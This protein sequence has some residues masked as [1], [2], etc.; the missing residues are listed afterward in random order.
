M[1]KILISGA[2]VLLL[3]VLFTVNLLK[4]EK[5]KE[6][7]A[8]KV[9]YG[10]VQQTVTGSGQIRPAVEVKVSAQ[11]AG[12][13]VQLNAKEGDRVK[14]G[15]LLAALDPEQYLASVERA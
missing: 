9:L 3:G 1:K 11:V 10:T 13:I 8:E 2:V 7:T 6:V 5:G 15:A 14:K 12:K 4:K